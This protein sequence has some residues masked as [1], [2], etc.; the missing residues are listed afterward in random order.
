LA[1]TPEGEYIYNAHTFYNPDMP[2]EKIFPKQ[3]YAEMIEHNN[4]KLIK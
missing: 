2:E 4:D 3:I 1:K